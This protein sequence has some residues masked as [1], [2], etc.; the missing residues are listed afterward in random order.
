VSIRFAAP[1]LAALLVACGGGDNSTAQNSAQA[2]A[3][4]ATAR[5]QDSA[6]ASAPAGQAAAQ[7]ARSGEQA[8]AAAAGG[9]SAAAVSFEVDTEALAAKAA[10]ASRFEANQ[11]YRRLSPAQPISTDTGQIEVAE[12][13]MYSCPGCYAFEPHITRWKERKADYVNLVRIPAMFHRVAIVHA[14]AYYTAEVLGITEEIHSAFFQEFHANN[15]MLDSESSLR[16][17]FGRFG[18]SEEDFTNAWNSFTVQFRMERARELAGRYTIGE[19]PTVVVHGKYVI[20]GSMA[21]S[22]DD[23]FEII[24]G[25]AAREM[26]AIS[27]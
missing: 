21:G 10:A 18:V 8:S 14:Q 27:E 26:L 3:G 9:D 19:T 15:N 22:Y 24:D 4:D 17:F 13:F 6:P 5:T 20:T 23:W 2:P 1:L 25:L 16:R 12:I 11:H 7:P